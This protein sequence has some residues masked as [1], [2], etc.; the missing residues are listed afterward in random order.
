MDYD[1]ISAYYFI[2][3]P[4]NNEQDKLLLENLKLY[5]EPFKKA[6][7]NIEFDDS[8]SFYEGNILEFQ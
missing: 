1:R 8:Y 7:Q 3:D 2:F 4:E 5:E 6:I